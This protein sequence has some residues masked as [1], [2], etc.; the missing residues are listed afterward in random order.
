MGKS[1]LSE[2][3]KTGRSVDFT[4]NCPKRQ[5]GK[6]CK[7]CYVECAREKGFNAKRI[8]DAKYDGFVLRMRPSTIRKLNDSGGI[9]L[10]S[11]GDYMP[12]M[13]AD[14]ISFLQDCFQVG[15]KA[16]AITKQIE[17]VE[18]FHDFHAI[19]VIHVSIDNVGDGVD[20]EIAKELRQRYA[21]VRIRSVILRDA[22]VGAMAFSD[23]FTFNHSHV[24]G[25]KRY[26]PDDRRDWS[27]RLNGRVCCVSE[28]GI[29]PKCVNCSLK[30][31]Q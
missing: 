31:A 27:E 26:S 9:R 3:L 13:D 11:F 19:S 29:E 12:H 16:K 5:A 4:T 22:D 23:V 24:P 28:P 21:K 8:Y 1:A 7:Y 6:P 15:L 20:W 2:N 17:F 25:Y 14:L 18:R 30:C 10:F